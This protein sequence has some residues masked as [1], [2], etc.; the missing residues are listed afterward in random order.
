MFEAIRTLYRTGRI[1][2]AGV[3]NAVRRGLITA[4]QY[5]IITGAACPQ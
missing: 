5:E 3:L 1:T 4:A 2:A